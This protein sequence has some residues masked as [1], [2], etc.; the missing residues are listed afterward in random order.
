MEATW[1]FHKTWLVES[2]WICTRLQRLHS[3]KKGSEVAGVLA[4]EEAEGSVIRWNRQWKKVKRKRERKEKER[5]MCQCA[6][7]T[8][9]QHKES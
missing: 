3:K 5:D 6:S 1:Y 7:D 9:K 4:S 2:R 8:I